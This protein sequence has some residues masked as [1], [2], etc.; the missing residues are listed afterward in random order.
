LRATYGADD[1]FCTALTSTRL[2]MAAQGRIPPG[3]V[4]SAGSTGRYTGKSPSK[5]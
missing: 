4:E 5:K 3:R 2:G 1:I